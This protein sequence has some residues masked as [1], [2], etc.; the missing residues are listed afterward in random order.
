MYHR[1]NHKKG[2]KKNIHIYAP[3]VGFA[4]Y[5]RT[6]KRRSKIVSVAEDSVLYAENPRLHQK[7]LLELIK[8]LAK[9]GD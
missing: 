6:H 9:L 7:K 8:N 1:C 2:K 3:N 5:I 4:K